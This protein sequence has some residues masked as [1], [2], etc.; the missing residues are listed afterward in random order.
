MI[1]LSNLSTLRLLPTYHCT[2]KTYGRSTLMLTGITGT[3]HTLYGRLFMVSPIEPHPHCN[4]R[5]ELVSQLTNGQFNSR[6]DDTKAYVDLYRFIM[7]TR[8]SASH[9]RLW[10][11]ITTMSPKWNRNL[12]QIKI[13]ILYNIIRSDYKQ[14]LI[15][16]L[17]FIIISSVSIYKRY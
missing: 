13:I 11:W 15:T 6:C 7:K 8:Q 14:M 12:K 4:C 9:N 3:T 1:P 5:S 17:V 2:N 16:Y 10:Q